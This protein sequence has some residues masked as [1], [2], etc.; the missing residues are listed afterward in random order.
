MENRSSANLYSGSGLLCMAQLQKDLAKGKKKW[1]LKSQLHDTQHVCPQIRML[2]LREKRDRDRYRKTQTDTESGGRDRDRNKN[3]ETERDRDRHL[4][5][6]KPVPTRL[7]HKEDGFSL[8][9]CTQSE[10]LL[11]I[12]TVAFYCILLAS[13]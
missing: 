9:S 8:K 2:Q 3:R 10:H 7:L 1:V 4:V 11:L 13:S 6:A 12:F 5:F